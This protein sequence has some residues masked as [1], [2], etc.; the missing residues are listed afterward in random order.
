M[1]R[2]AQ[3]FEHRPQVDLHHLLVVLV[4]QLGEG[5]H[6]TDAGVIDEYVHVRRERLCGVPQAGSSARLGQVGLDGPRLAAGG[7]HAGGDLLGGT[8]F[9]AVAEGHGG[10]VASQALHYRPPNP[11]RA[12]GNERRPPVEHSA[13]IPALSRRRTFV[14]KLRTEVPRIVQDITRC[15]GLVT[16]T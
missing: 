8:L 10:A 15:R 7:G 11:T 12:A 3:G 4:G 1:R 9:D 13:Q 16:S 14:S 5:P 2:D 6:D